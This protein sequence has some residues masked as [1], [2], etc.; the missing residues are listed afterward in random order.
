MSAKKSKKS[1]K[2]G[3]LGGLGGLFGS[4]GGSSRGGGGMARF[5]QRALSRSKSPSSSPSPTA[6][7][8]QPSMD[9][10]ALIDP[11]FGRSAVTN[12]PSDPLEAIVSLQTFAGSWAWNEAL[13]GVLGLDISR[14][15]ALEAQLGAAFASG[16]DV[17]ATA[18]VLA[19]LEAKLARRKDEWEMMAEKASDWLAEQLTAKG[20]GV[21]AQD[22]I[23]KAKT[24]I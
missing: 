9:S 19:Y 3:V 4:S 21:A 8:V 2:G 18:L 1:A 23:A 10:E 17:L 7:M 16:T 5:S 15:K 6:E 20:N 13:F 14:V 11:S 12:I 24:V 22:Y